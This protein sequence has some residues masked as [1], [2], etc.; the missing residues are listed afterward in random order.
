LFVIEGLLQQV[1]KF[2]GQFGIGHR[3]WF[4]LL[5]LIVL[6]RQHFN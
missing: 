5:T 1:Q 2:D 6:C 3:L 4:D